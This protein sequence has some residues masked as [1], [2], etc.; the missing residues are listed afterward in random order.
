[1]RTNRLS[2]LSVFWSVL[3]DLLLIGAGIVL[4]LWFKIFGDDLLFL[5]L[6]ETIGDPQTILLLVALFSMAVG[7]LS[8]LRTLYRVLQGILSSRRVR[9]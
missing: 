9:E 6:L 1:M 7:S 4:Y 3:I 8:L 2:L 5:P